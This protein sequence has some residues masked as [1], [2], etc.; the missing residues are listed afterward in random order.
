MH[1]SIPR[2]RERRASTR[3]S[4]KQ[5]VFVYDPADALEEVY[6]GWIVDRSQG[7]VCLCLSRSDIEEGSI[8]VV[9]PTSQPPLPGIEVC[10]R[11]RRHRQGNVYLGCEFMR[12]LAARPRC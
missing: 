1:V 5:R 7:G 9:R 11:N 6:A 8:L 10:V 2:L 12:R 3:V 4:S